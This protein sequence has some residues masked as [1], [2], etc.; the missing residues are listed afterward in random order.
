MEGLTCDI[1]GATFK[2]R[3]GLGGHRASIH[4]LKQPKKPKIKDFLAEGLGTI[5]HRLSILEG[6]ITSLER[7]KL[8]RPLG[9]GAPHIADLA[10]A[11]A[12]YLEKESRIC[13]ANPFHQ[14]RPI[15]RIKKAL[16]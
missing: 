9:E 15:E 8:Q 7:A 2:N 16:R 10:E 14:P 13:D 3:A 5:S 11:L 1:C 12:L 6:R 4:G